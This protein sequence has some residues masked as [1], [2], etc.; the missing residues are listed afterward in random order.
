VPWR[1]SLLEALAL[2]ELFHE[3]ALQERN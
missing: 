3:D 1:Q 2:C